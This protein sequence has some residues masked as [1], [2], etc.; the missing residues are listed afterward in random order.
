[1]FAGDPTRPRRIA[2][3]AR[4]AAK[5]GFSQQLPKHGGRPFARAPAGHDTRAICP[6]EILKA[7]AR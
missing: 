3:S 1:M 7:L 2:I 4:H 6:R 5:C